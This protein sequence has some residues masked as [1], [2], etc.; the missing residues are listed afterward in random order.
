MAGS[1]QRRTRLRLGFS[2]GFMVLGLGCRVQDFRVEGL[3]LKDLLPFPT[4]RNGS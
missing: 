3:G 4:C 2:L 1:T